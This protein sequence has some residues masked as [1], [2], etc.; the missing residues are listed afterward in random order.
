M[1]IGEDN[2][3][4][5]TELKS[6]YGASQSIDLMGF[7]SVLFAP[8]IIQ[9]SVCFTGGLA[10]PQSQRLSPQRAGAVLERENSGFSANFKNGE[11]KI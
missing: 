7:S 4:H 8:K 9:F 11:M 6:G 10:H 5:N 1:K 2:S 3:S